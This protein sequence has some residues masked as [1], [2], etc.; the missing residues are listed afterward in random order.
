[1]KKIYIFGN[2][3]MEND[4]L[5]IKL[6]PDLKKAFPKIE[7]I[8]QD[9]NDNLHPDNKELTIIDSVEGINEIKILTDIEQIIDSPK[10]SMHDLDLGFTLKLLK[11]I[12]ALDQVTIYCVPMNGEPKELFKQL[13]ESLAAMAAP[14][15]SQ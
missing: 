14:L 12:G 15:P 6:I 3:L 2:S 13:C 10:Y 5:P 1:M 11:K 7:F 8:H 4:N 9:P